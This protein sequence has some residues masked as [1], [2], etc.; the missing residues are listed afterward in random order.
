MRQKSVHP[1]SPSERMLKNIRRVTRK[2]HSC[3]EKMF[4]DRQLDLRSSRLQSAESLQCMREKH[5]N[6]YH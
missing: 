4:Y 1:K 6:I 3:E 2:R 5:R